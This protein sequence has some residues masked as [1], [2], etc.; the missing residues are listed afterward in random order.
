M[1]DEENF[2]IDLLRRTQRRVNN[3]AND[4]YEKKILMS[5]VRIKLTKKKSKFARESMTKQSFVQKKN[6]IEKKNVDDLILSIS[7]KQKIAKFKRKKKQIKKIKSKRETKQLVRNIESFSNIVTLTKSLLKIVKVR[8]KLSKNIVV[9]SFDDKKMKKVVN[10]Y[11]FIESLKNESLFSIK[12]N[13][14]MF[15]KSSSFEKSNEVLNVFA[16]SILIS[17]KK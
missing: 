7:K 9:N 14:I 16:S 5:I 10:F 2:K 15:K 11:D 17:R 8:E 13:K 1:H 12:K 4:T 6:L 3:V